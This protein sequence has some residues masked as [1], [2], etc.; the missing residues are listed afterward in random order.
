MGISS[1]NIIWY[2]L[3]II[4]HSLRMD[5]HHHHH[6]PHTHAHTQML[7]SSDSVCTVPLLLFFIYLFPPP[8]SSTQL[9]QLSLVCTV[10][11]NLTMLHPFYW[12]LQV[13]IL[14]ELLCWLMAVGIQ[15][16]SILP[17]PSGGSNVLLITRRCGTGKNKGKDIFKTRRLSHKILS[18]LAFN[19][20]LKIMTHP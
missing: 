1:K 11:S 14:W 5:H 4:H 12:H 16:V 15:L 10:A 3:G 7:A 13:K 17:P 18:F 8:K 2:S 19:N 6:P 9:W 20:Y